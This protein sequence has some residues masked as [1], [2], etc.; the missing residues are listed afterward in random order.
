MQLR[1]FKCANCETS[2]VV[3]F[4][5]FCGSFGMP[6]E[7]MKNFLCNNE[8]KCKWFHSFL[9]PQRIREKVKVRLIS[10]NNFLGDTACNKIHKIAVFWR[11]CHKQALVASL[12]HQR[13]NL[14]RNLGESEICLTHT[15]RDICSTKTLPKQV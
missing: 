15:K 5:K 8:A 13:R 14:N 3:N 9:E 4:M 12:Y 2:K 6:K 11:D 7:T 1:N 10:L